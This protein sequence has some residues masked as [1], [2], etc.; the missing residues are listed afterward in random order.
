MKLGDF[1]GIK[2]RV[3]EIY[4]E[5]DQVTQVLKMSE[6]ENILLKNEI[7]AKDRQYSEIETI[8][9]QSQK[10]FETQIDKLKEGLSN[11][12]KELHFEI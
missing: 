12:E 8:Q 9:I 3:N 6:E 5:K 1:E 7:L 4:K 10:E 11:T 2:L